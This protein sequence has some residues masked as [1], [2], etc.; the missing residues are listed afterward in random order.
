MIPVISSSRAGRN[1]YYFAAGHGTNE[2]GHRG[3][4]AVSRKK[5]RLSWKNR[6]R[7][8][9]SCCIRGDFYAVFFACFGRYRWFGYPRYDRGWSRFGFF[10]AEL[11]LQRRTR[12]NTV[13]R[14]RHPISAEEDRLPAG[15]G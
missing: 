7:R 15:E 8:Q 6:L 10:E 14:D 11:C 1:D 4:W 2:D 9:P 13:G 12:K 5:L 3:G